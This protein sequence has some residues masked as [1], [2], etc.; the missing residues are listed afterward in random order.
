M[1]Q[2][3]EIC[4]I[5]IVMFSYLYSYNNKHNRF[6]WNLLTLHYH[7]Y[8]FIIIKYGTN[9]WTSPRWY[10]MIIFVWDS[11]VP[12]PWFSSTDQMSNSRTSKVK[13]RVWGS[14]IWVGAIAVFQVFC[15]SLSEWSGHFSRDPAPAQLFGI[16]CQKTSRESR[17]STSYLDRLLLHMARVRF[18]SEQG[19]S[20]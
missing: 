17:Q 13:S 12:A 16:S 2:L 8:L 3:E 14:G 1:T 11:P 10:V 6:I 20:N 5:Y 9:C 7:T 19:R 15:P 18:R 4:G